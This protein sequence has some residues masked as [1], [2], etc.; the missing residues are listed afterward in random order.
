MPL[1]KTQKKKIIDDLKEKIEKQKIF[2]FVNLKGLKVK[3]LFNLK[4]KLKKVDS[5][6]KV[7]KKTLLK[8]ALKEKGVE[9]DIKKL[10]GEIASVFGFKDEI[11]P[12]KT[13][14]Q[15]SLENKNLKILGGYFEGKFLGAE[16]MI[17]LAQLPTKDELLGRL[18]GSI[19]APVSNFVYV[20]NANIKG[21]IQ[22]LKQIKT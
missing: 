14:Y 19:F 5:Q 2:F 18:V 1:N 3:D 21:L 10:E 22:V 6:L 7:S 17:M 13:T 4:K 11:L 8:L 15:F 12:A 16:E 9:L 20:L